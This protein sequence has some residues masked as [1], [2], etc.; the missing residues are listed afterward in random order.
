MLIATILTLLFLGSGAS[1][2]LDGIDQMKDNIKAEIVDEG[3]RKDALAIVKTMEA[4]SKEYEKADKKDE[5][6]LLELIQG[7]ESTT[8]ELKRIMDASFKQR[9]EYQQ[10]MLALRFELKDKLTQEQWEKIFTKN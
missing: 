8:A 10:A 4:T 1:P 6:E 5:K 7:Y 3:T 9:V 2:M